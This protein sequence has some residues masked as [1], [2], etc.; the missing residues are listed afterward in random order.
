MQL[1]GNSTLTPTQPAPLS[2]LSCP[3]LRG[4]PRPFMWLPFL[5]SPLASWPAADIRALQWPLLVG[6]EAPFLTGCHLWDKE[7]FPGPLE[8][9]CPPHPTSQV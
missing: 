3:P 5:L 1:L 7:T 8:G 2:R 9:A 4:G 6:R